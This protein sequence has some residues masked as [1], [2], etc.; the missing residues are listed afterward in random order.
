MAGD[1]RTSTPNVHA[2]WR[3]KIGMNYSFKKKRPG[4]SRPL[5]LGVC[6]KQ[7]GR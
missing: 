6:V 3:G 4:F 7:L 1:A 5:S 2:A